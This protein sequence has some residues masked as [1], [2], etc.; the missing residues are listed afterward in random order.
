MNSPKTTGADDIKKD[1]AQ[2][3]IFLSSELG[4]S[5]KEECQTLR[6]RAEERLPPQSNHT[7]ILRHV[8]FSLALS[9]SVSHPEI[10]IYRKQVS[11]L[12][13]NAPRALEIMSM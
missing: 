2:C 8:G 10:S 7:P 9:V 5:P 6:T 1:A 3:G 11:N 12:S 13:D 4:H